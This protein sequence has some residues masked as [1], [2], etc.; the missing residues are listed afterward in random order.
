MA[1]A[2]LKDFKLEDFAH[3][4][5]GSGG[6]LSEDESRIPAVDIKTETDAADTQHQLIHLP[7]VS[8]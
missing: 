7:C 4:T 8:T 1:N 6:E 3:K 2:S 5:E